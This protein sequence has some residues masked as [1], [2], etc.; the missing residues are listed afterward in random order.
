MRTPTFL[1][2]IGHF[3]RHNRQL[4]LLSLALAAV[5]LYAIRSVTS[6]ELTV[7][8]IPIQVMAADGMA[9]LN[10]SVV[11]VDATFRGAQSDINLLDRAR[12][13]AVVDI[14]D[15]KNPGSCDAPIES[16]DIQGA[17]RVAVLRVAPA[18][19]NVSLDQRGEK[20]APVIARRAGEPLE[21]SVE[22]MECEPA[23]VRIR[24]PVRR[25][26]ETDSV[27][28]EPID[29]GGRVESF[30]KRAQVLPPSDMWVSHIEPAE[31]TVKV[32]ITR[33]SATREWRKV[34]LQVLLEPGRE[35]VVELRPLEVGV[36]LKGRA[37]ELDNMAEGAVTAFINCIGRDTG[38]YNLPVS[39]HVAGSPG[40]N[41]EASP[42]TAEVV[43]KR[44]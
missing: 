10:Q 22:N 36:V 34:P 26:H 42:A 44:R 20:E 21:G 1:D 8:E 38:A 27:Y 14:R 37:A 13:K 33:K 12:L 19:V 2:A 11:T 31:V 32:T 4:K 40:L 16:G 29:V 24:G 30:T 17:Q 43:L 41:A 5:T 15:K 39:V 3:A 28:T 6:F 35:S 18:R 25:L 7:R 9:I 23:S